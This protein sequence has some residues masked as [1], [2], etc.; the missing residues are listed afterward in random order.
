MIDKI[1]EILKEFNCP[2]KYIARPNF[3]DGQAVVISFHDYNRRGAYYG[4][5]ERKQFITNLQIDIFHKRDLKGLDLKIIKKL[6]ENNFIFQDSSNY[7]DSLSG[8]RLYHT[9]LT[10]EYLEREVE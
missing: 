8:I 3:K 6:E 1:Y 5:G 4:D 2:V 9:V 10:F 7:D